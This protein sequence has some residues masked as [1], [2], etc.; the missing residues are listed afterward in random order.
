MSDFVSNIF[1][2]LSVCCFING[3]GSSV[4]GKFLCTGFKQRNPRKFCPSKMYKHAVYHC[5]PQEVP[6]GVQCECL[7]GFTGER[8]EEDRNECVSYPDICSDRG[9]CT[10]TFGSYNCSCYE[11]YEVQF[12]GLCRVIIRT[13]S[14]KYLSFVTREG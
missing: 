8:C 2:V 9:N 10:N 5:I 13:I 12:T 14:I 7:D 11:Q 1:M 4:R 6:G 3:Y